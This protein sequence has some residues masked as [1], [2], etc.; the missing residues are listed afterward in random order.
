MRKN[1]QCV[2]VLLCVWARAC[3]GAVSVV[4]HYFVCCELKIAY[5]AVLTACAF[6][7]VRGCL[8]CGLCVIVVAKRVSWLPTVDG[9]TA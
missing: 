9:V 1:E 3:R 7:A 8:L 2:H 5:V 4:A 6:V